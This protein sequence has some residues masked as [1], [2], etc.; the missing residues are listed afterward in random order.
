MQ[1][2][3]D[4]LVIGG[5]VMG[6]SVAYWLTRMAPGTKVRVVEMD[7]SYTYASTALSVASIRSQF[8]NP[9]NVQISRLRAR[10]HPRFCPV[11][12]LGRRARSWG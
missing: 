12:A 7:P 10:V 3:P 5:G 9:V 8:S 2:G 11:R 4:V 1:T 6:A